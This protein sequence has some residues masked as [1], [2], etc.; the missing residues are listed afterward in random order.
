VALSAFGGVVTD[1]ELSG[2][3]REQMAG[4]PEA[5]RAQWPELVGGAQRWVSL[6]ADIAV[7]AGVLDDED[8][9]RATLAMRELTLPDALTALVRQV[10]PLGLRPDPGMAPTE[11][12]TDLSLRSSQALNQRLGMEPASEERLFRNATREIAHTL[13]ILRDGD[14]HTRFWLWLDQLYF[15]FYR[16]WRSIRLPLMAAQEQRAIAALGGREGAGPPR[17]LSWLPPQNA[18]IFRAAAADLVRSGLPVFFWTEPFGFFDYWGF[19]PVTMIVS[20]GEPSTAFES[21]RAEAAEI[22]ERVK[23]L[24]DPSRLVILRIIRDFA[25]DNTQMADYLGLARPT[26]SIHAKL[27]R[28]AGLINTRQEGRASVHTLNVGEVRRLFQDLERFLRLPEE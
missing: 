22:A 23:A 10:A 14:L 12:F 24:S 1:R 11:Q 7:L 6:L 27:L 21:F 18:L 13:R 5:W 8:Y 25:M 28:E 2:Q 17:H 4:V 20:Y 9:S 3:V 19:N 15:E 16:P 26:V